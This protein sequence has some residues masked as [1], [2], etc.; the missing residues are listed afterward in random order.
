MVETLL[1]VLVI[2]SL[3]LG[4]FELSRL[5]MA[6]VMGEHAAMRVARARAVGLNEFQCLKTGRIAMIPSSGRRLHPDSQDERADIGEAALARV[7]MRTPDSVY[8]DGLLRYEHWDR[9][10]VTP[11]RGGVSAVELK[12]DWCKVRGEAFVDGFPVYLNDEGL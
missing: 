5:L 1:A 3:F 4:L 12:T 2:T 6:K 7:Y 10:Q 8:A 9:L 11:G